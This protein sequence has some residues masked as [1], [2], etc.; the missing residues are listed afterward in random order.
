[1]EWMDA[2]PFITFILLERFQQFSRFVSD[3]CHVAE[4]T[5]FLDSNQQSILPFQS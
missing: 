2:D 1:M 3:L 4:I 5:G